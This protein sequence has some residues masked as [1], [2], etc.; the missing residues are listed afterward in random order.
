VRHD[1]RWLKRWRMTYYGCCEPLDG[2]MDVL[3]RIPNLRKIS[4]SPWIDP[5]RAVRVVGG[6][7][8][9]SFKPSPAVLAE[10]EWNLAKARADLRA[11]L[12]KTR[13]CHVEVILKDVST[14]RHQ[15]QRLWEWAR[16][17]MELA[18]EFGA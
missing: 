2:K 3:R 12:D 10:D 5:D 8:V 1:L 11:V 7:Y 14:V 6:N 17:A 13:G 15:P 16:M 4:M 9:F 18:E